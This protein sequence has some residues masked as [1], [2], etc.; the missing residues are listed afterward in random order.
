MYFKK[1]AY[2][3]LTFI[4]YYPFISKFLYII[5]FYIF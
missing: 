4:I 3:V 2:F 1:S 5:A